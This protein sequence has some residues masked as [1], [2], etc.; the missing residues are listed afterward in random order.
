MYIMYVKFT[1]CS[2]P[3]LLRC[4]PGGP[5]G[6]R[7]SSRFNRLLETLHLQKEIKKKKDW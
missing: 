3:I 2:P 4:C 7:A 1:V 6:S 5:D